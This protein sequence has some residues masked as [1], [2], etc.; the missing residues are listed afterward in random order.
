MREKEKEKEGRLEVKINEEVL[1]ERVEL[2]GE[3]MKRL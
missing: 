2:R 3:M 1:L